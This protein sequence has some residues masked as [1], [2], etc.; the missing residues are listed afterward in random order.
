MT[1]IPNP[2]KALPRWPL[3]HG[4]F[5]ALHELAV[6]F[7]YDLRS[8]ISFVGMTSAILGNQH[9][10]EGE[11]ARTL[12]AR[13]EE[14][15]RC[16]FVL[17][18]DL[19]VLMGRTGRETEPV[20]LQEALDTVLRITRIE[21]E[22]AC[23]LETDFQPGLPRVPGPGIWLSRVFFGLVINA[24]SAMRSQA[25][26]QHVLGIRTRQHER[27]V[28]V[29]ISATGP[30]LPPEAI[31]HLFD[32]SSP[33]PVPGS[34]QWLGLYRLQSL[35]EDMGGE[36]RVESQ[37]DRGMTFDVLLPVDGRVDEGPTSLPLEGPELRVL[38]NDERNTMRALM[39]CCA[40]ELVALLG[41]LS[42]LFKQLAGL[43]EEGDRRRRF[44]RKAL[45]TLRRMR[46]WIRELRHL[47][48][49][50]P[51]PPLPV[52]VD[53]CLLEALRITRDELTKTARVEEDFTP[54]LP[55]VLGSGGH[56]LRMFLLLLRVSLRAMR[57][58]PPRQHVLRVRTLREDGWVRVTLS[59]T[60]DGIPPEKLPFLLDDGALLHETNSSFD[61]FGLH[62][63][64][65]LVQ[66]LGG[67]LS[68]ASEEGSSGMSY[69]VR[70]PV[71]ERP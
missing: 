26:Q 8:A 15:C 21:R 70:L 62:I 6:C 16:V 22:H 36:L 56:V 63:S 41:A 24:V 69:S 31:P 68:I 2:G 29:T 37:P 25:P 65:A 32:P 7:T 64:H 52:H 18:E 58:G 1:S 30:G 51:E 48:Y 5:E 3:R 57:N 28:R 14:S 66:G 33:P 19:Y 46:G 45:R 61:A 20:E 39:A 40:R 55:C 38:Q 35:V 54:D 27:S 67:E 50:P 42:T 43:L 71:A 34:G 59:D 49:R 4:A 11:E 9:L 53:A 60:S 47:R 13:A 10:D 12:V 44:L 17:L 23:R